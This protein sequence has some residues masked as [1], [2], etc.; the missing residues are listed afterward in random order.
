M[1]ISGKSSQRTR[2]ISGSVSRFWNCTGNICQ[3]RCW[4]SSAS[5]DS[6]ISSRQ[7]TRCGGITSP[8]PERSN[9]AWAAAGLFQRVGYRLMPS[10]INRADTVHIADVV[11]LP[12]L[13]SRITDARGCSTLKSGCCGA[14]PRDVVPAGRRLASRQPAAKRRSPLLLGP[15]GKGMERNVAISRC[16]QAFRAYAAGIPC[17]A[18]AIA[19]TN[20]KRGGQLELAP[21]VLFSLAPSFP[22]PALIQSRTLA[23]SVCPQKKISLQAAE[24]T[25]S[26]QSLRSLGFE[27]K[28]GSPRQART[29]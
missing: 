28:L 10:P 13:T 29:T 6:V 15:V 21:P 1:R 20:A 2:S 3:R 26:P 16:C 4:N 17:C 23:Q 24:V 22:L 25:R 5:A 8:M 7:I 14:A 11:E 12:I 9:T 27:A 18:Q 19:E